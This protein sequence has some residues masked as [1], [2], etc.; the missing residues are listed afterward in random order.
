MI[1][2]MTSR[3]TILTALLSV[4]LSLGLTAPVRAQS[5][6]ALQSTPTLKVFVYGFPRLSP[7]VVQDAERE[8]TRMLRTVSIEWKWINCTSR[9][10]SE[11]CLSP[12]LP[13]DL[14]IR[15]LPKALP[16]ASVRALGAAASSADYATAFIFYDRILALRTHTHLLPPMLGRVLAHEITHL[17]S[18]QEHHTGFG[19]MRRQWSADDLLFTSSA[20]LGLSAKSVQIM[21]RE[22]LRRMGI[23]DGALQK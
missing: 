18:P 22:A 21:H 13:A 15:F 9:V 11:S 1:R 10:L 3:H 14:T 19:L 7:S 17:L 20:C 6:I 8:A 16:E 23:A 2:G 5:L 4:W 12:Q